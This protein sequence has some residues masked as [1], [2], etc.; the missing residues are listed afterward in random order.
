MPRYP[1]RPTPDRLLFKVGDRVRIVPIDEMGT[2][3]KIRADASGDWLI[4]VV[5]DT[6]RVAHV[7][8]AFEI[9]KKCWCGL[10]SVSGRYCPAGHA[11]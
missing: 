7:C 1:P 6:D 2:V 10:E 5:R 3:E 8:R 9:R 4:D 11:L